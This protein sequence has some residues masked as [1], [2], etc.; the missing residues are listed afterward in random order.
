MTRL[1]HVFHAGVEDRPGTALALL[2]AW[3]AASR[4]RH[5][6][7]V[8]GPSPVIDEARQLGLPL[9]AAMGAPHGLATMAA[10]AIAGVLSREP[11]P[12]AV[13]CWSLGAMQ[14]VRLI[15]PKRPAT[16]C[17][18]T[19]PAPREARRLASLMSRR[20]APTAVVCFSPGTA[21]T[22]VDAG[23]LNEG[24]HVVRPGVEPGLLETSDRHALRRSWGVVDPE[25]PVAIA[26]TTPPLAADAERA[27]LALG[28]A[29]EAMGNPG[30]LRQ[31]IRLLCHPHQLRREL[32][33]RVLGDIDM[34]DLIV[35]EPQVATPWLVLPGVDVALV[36]GHHG[37]RLA[38]AWAMTAGR[39]LV[40]G[41]RSGAMDDI[42]HEEHALLAKSHAPRDF[43]HCIKQILEDRPR[44]AGLGERAA[45]RAGERFDPATMARR[46]DDITVATH[47]PGDPEVARSRH[48]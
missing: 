15:S 32:A 45:A 20:R 36:F 18:T 23:C 19:R 6:V 39:P 46:L 1:H 48:A 26:L 25:T 42:R 47:A 16:L 30:S 37:D 43:A 14:A 10:P 2:H 5:R 3:I 34:P 44:A 35:Q 40:A 31:S 28:M 11:S 27:G 22:L 12:D 38:R 17:Q 7:T 33:Q 13:V 41:P 24:L 29:A 8:L 21:E 4:H 9:A